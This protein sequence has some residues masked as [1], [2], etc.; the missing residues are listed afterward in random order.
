MTPPLSA[1]V[2]LP[3]VVRKSILDLAENYEGL[4]LSQRNI[5]MK[6]VMAAHSD[7]R[8]CIYL[9]RHTEEEHHIYVL[10]MELVT[11]L[12]SHVPCAGCWEMYYN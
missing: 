5:N 7:G 11:E 8:V 3:G 2:I 9:G 6:E 10:T 1:G 4:K 12:D